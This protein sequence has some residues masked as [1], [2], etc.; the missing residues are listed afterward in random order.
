[1]K[2]LKWRPLFSVDG[3][4]QPPQFAQSAAIA[5]SATSQLLRALKRHIAAASAWINLDCH[6]AAVGEEGC[7]FRRGLS[8]CGQDQ[9]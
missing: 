6:E 4:S 5:A 2:S 1:M 8:I 7:R 3:R 9:R